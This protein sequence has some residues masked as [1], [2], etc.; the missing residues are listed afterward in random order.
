[1]A[2]KLVG[3]DFT[4][5]D[6]I[7]KV[8]GQAKYAED[9]RA[10]GM[11]FCRLL[12][13]PMP[14]ARV[15]SI[16]ASE[17]LKM[18][19]VVGVLTPDDVTPQPDPMPPILAREPRYVGEPIVAVAAVDET[20]AQN[21]IEK[22]KVDLEPLP[23]TVDPLQ[24]LFPGGPNARTDGNV[25]M[26]FP[27]LPA[28]PVQTFKWT[29]ADF[30][31]ANEGQM[32]MGKAVEEWSYGDVEGSFAKA[33]LV[34]DE[35]FVTAA[36]SH[37]SM[38]PRSCMAYWQNGKCFVHGSSQSHTFIIP[39][40]AGLIGIKP[41]EV[42][43]IAEYCG[44]GFGSKGNAYPVMAIPAL[45][46]K[47]IGKPVMMRISRA[48]EYF[49][50]S[51]RSGFQGRIKLGFRAD[52]KLLAADLYV[53]QEGG[54][55]TGFWDYRNAGDAVSLVYQPLA[56]RWRGVPVYGNTPMRTAQRGPGYNQIMCA[57]E[58][59]MDRA[60]RE[61]GVDR[62]QMRLLNCP[63]GGS[64]FGGR[65]QTVSSCYLKD[66]LTKGAARFKWDEKKKLS[67]KR[68]GSKVTGVAVAQ[69]Y[70]PAGAFGFDGLV[71]ITPDGKLHIHNGVGNLGTFSH[72]G[73]ARIAAEVLKCDWDNCILE[74]GDSRKHL[75]WNL[76][77]FGSNTSYT[78]S[79][80]NFVAA[81][82]AVAKLKEIAAKDLGGKP[83]DYEID[84]TKVFAKANPSK[85][86][87]YGAA[88]QR[89][90]DLGGKYC[91]KEMPDDINPI[92]KSS[93]TALAGTGLIGVAKDKLPVNGQPAAF[94]AAFIQIELDLETGQHRILDF[95]SV[96]DCGTVIHPQGLSTQLK[97]GSVQ[98]FGM[99][100]LEHMV[101]DPQNGL[102][103][104][105]G[106][107][108]AK[109]ATYLDMPLEMHT[110]AVDKPDPTSPLGTKGVGEPPLGSA[111][112]ALLCAI[113][114]ALGGHV[115]NRTPVSPDM[116]VNFTAGRPQSHKPLQVNTF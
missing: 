27:P 96:G 22:I 64:K 43:L 25:G 12:L 17:A 110:D 46:S 103:A 48:E 8:T 84:G 41:E 79:R 34:Y 19:G 70:H 10:D 71:R 90:I 33:K 81:T 24:S 28:T 35:S 115:F 82:D 83:D 57:V 114:D 30:A 107:H 105:V 23:F 26:V 39:T 95:L 78:M 99:A 38:E 69:A 61:L 89:A 45:M 18:E 60:A 101:Y 4:P 7:A 92:T 42:V 109:P 9:F 106:L 29:A 85:S 40:L 86:L 58:P 88:A 62:L 50:G 44:G 73:T 80:T 14:H 1:M 113:S 76:G 74:R 68:N 11:V 102:P 56:M 13:S 36:I 21:A 108:Q 55:V 93:V 16:D 104:T 72:S 112:A 37:H 100:C 116:I 51:G 31:R 91:G 67:G 77:Q 87:T 47:K 53:V 59:L 20:T 6:V 32:P 75:P 52:G 3:K 15:R 97:G 5:H 63:Q 66:A 54:P 94:I 98:G 65:Q 111:A 49:T 2:Y